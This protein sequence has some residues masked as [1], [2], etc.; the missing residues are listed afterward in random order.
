MAVWK[1]MW[2][3]WICLALI[4]VLIGAGIEIPAYTLPVQAAETA[5]QETG[6]YGSQ[7]T[8]VIEKSMY[9]QLTAHYAMQE[10]TT[11]LELDTAEFA[12]Q[13]TFTAQIQEG[14]IVED[15]SFLQVKLEVLQAYYRAMY[16]FLYDNPTVYWIYGF[17]IQYA[18]S[19]VG[20]KGSITSIK[21]IPNVY[22]SGAETELGEFKQA[23]ENTF[24]EISASLPQQ[25][26][27]YY[28]VKAI[29]D[30]LCK[31]LTYHEDAAV[32]NAEQYLYA[33]TAAGSFIKDKKVVCEGYAKAFKILCDKFEIPCLLVVGTGVTGSGGNAH[34]WNYVQ[35][36]DGQWY[37]V[38][39]TW[40]DQQAAWDAPDKIRTEYLLAGSG[41]QGFHKTFIE[42]HVPEPFGE[43]PGIQFQLPTL[44]AVSYG[45]TCTHTYASWKTVRNAG[46]ITAGTAERFCTKC[47]EKETKA[48]AALGH[49]YGT[50]VVTKKATVLKTGIKTQTCRRCGAKQ[51]IIIPALAAP[52]KGT[53]FTAGNLK[54]R[55]TKAG[56]QNGT[57]E[58]A[59]VKAKSVTSV[60]IPTTVKK[61]GVTYRVTG[62]GR[63]AFYR[64]KK[65]KRV[66]IGKYI[67]AIGAKAFQECN[68]L[69]TVTLPAGVSKIETRAFYKCKSLQKIT[70]KTT[71]LTKS[72]VGKDAFKG[73]SVN[74]KLQVP[75]KKLKVYKTIFTA[76]GI[77]K[78]AEI[79]KG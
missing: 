8:S 64:C 14:E 52:K 73:V 61:N 41:E 49:Q 22:Y 47:K 43:N 20:G 78:K 38:D 11:E 44:A 54:Y 31:T 67:T 53:I 16:A 23:V 51:N 74:V 25:S 18:Y 71:K 62:I 66:T 24:L 48:L 76:K 4:I 69:K 21:L 56:V 29:H 42:E 79:V 1:K 59:G 46:C 32:N 34:M 9:R 15:E 37:G 17:Q 75:K 26:S 60:K 28:E 3:Q 72:R 57:V 58:V 13:L 39:V 6:Y 70:V 19:A 5:A 30:Y 45:K 55:V 33:H 50:A 2:K 7:M 68:A 36:E 63:T 65:L 12:E 40:D 10:N 27:R 77:S 35:M